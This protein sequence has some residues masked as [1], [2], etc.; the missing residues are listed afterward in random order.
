MAASKPNSAISFAH[1]SGPPAEPITIAA[2][3]LRASCPATLPTAPRGRGDVDDVAVS[4]RSNVPESGV[5][6]QAGRIE[7]R[8]GRRARVSTMVASVASMTE[9]FWTS[10][11]KAR[12]SRA[13]GYLR[14]R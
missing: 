2:P 5:G 7:T 1:F 8:P 14:L 12:P 4:H 11:L 6:G 3:N 9:Y 10:M 13:V